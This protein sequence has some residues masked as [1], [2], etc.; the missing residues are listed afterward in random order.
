M[1]ITSERRA[2]KPLAAALAEFAA[3]IMI[4]V[5]LFMAMVYLAY[6]TAMYMYI[7]TGVN[8]AARVEARWLALNFN[9]LVQ[10]NGNSTADYANW[11][12]NNVRIANC[13]VSSVQFT[14]GTID[15]NGKFVAEAPQIHTTGSCQTSA[16]GLGVVAVK[17]S[18]PGGS[19]LADWPFPPINLFGATIAPGNF[20]IAGIYCAD[21]E[22]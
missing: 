11:K 3:A 20:Q 6:Q 17:V 9:Y 22:P 14:N 21:V 13:V 10:R 1:T 15:E 16:G 7:K 4:M 2:R 5:P 8:A 12:N 19:G 18:Y